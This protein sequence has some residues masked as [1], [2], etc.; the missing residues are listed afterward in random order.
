MF[1]VNSVELSPLDESH[2]VWELESDDPPRPKETLK[3]FC[4]IINIGH[5]SQNIIANDQVRLAVLIYD[6][7]ACRCPKN[8]RFTSIP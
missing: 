8:S 1:M 2:N 6:C 5:V 4:E 3:A 7:L